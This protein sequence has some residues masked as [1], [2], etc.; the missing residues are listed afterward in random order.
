MSLINRYAVVTGGSR[1]I[2]AA[3]ALE[4][5]KRGANVAVT[6]TSNKMQAESVR[7]QIVALGRRSIIIQADQG[8]LDV[9]EV[10]LKGLKDGFGIG[11]EKKLDILVI[12]G[13]VTGP[14]PTLDWEIEKF[15]SFMN[16]NV[17][18]PMLLVRDLAPHLSSSGRIIANTSVIV[19][20]PYPIQDA[21]AASKAALEALVRQWAVTLPSQFPGVTA[22]AIAPGLVST[23]MVKGYEHLFDDVKKMT[24]V[25]NRLGEVGDIAELVGWMA[26]EGTR[27]M[28]GQT[29]HANGGL[30]MA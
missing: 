12:N 13:G 8:T 4:L 26:E 16:I 10:V 5:A 27:F 11:S 6:Y 15:T 9:G 14:T 23:D 3:I 1:G 2:G 30:F 22:N 7:D 29:I 19:R 20:R 17:R 28:N 25:G 18:G 21:Y 24:P